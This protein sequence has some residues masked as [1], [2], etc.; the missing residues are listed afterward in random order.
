MARRMLRKIINRVKEKAEKAWQAATG[1]RHVAPEVV[2]SG[3]K[4]EEKVLKESIQEECARALEKMKREYPARGIVVHF[5]SKDKAN[6]QYEVHGLLKLEDGDLHSKATDKD[7]YYALKNVL[8]ELANQ[9]QR[10]RSKRG[11]PF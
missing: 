7:P 6:R 2:V 5:K 11:K 4:P 1:G 10:V 8:D 3:L 9:L